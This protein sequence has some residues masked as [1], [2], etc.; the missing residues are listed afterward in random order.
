MGANSPLRLRSLAMIWV[1]LRGVSPSAPLPARKSGIAIGMGWTL[2]W[3]TS[4]L[5]TACARR[6]ARPTTAPAA[7]PVSNR[8]RLVSPLSPS[9]RSSFH[10]L[11]E[12]LN[13][14]GADAAALRN[15]SCGVKSSSTTL[16]HDAYWDAGRKRQGAPLRI[17]RSE[18]SAATRKAGFGLLL[19]TIGSPCSEP[20]R[21]NATRTCTTRSATSS[22]PAGMSQNDSIRARNAPIQLC[23]RNCEFGVGVPSAAVLMLVLVMVCRC[24]SRLSISASLLSIFD[25]SSLGCG[26]FL[27]GAGGFGSGFLASFLSA[28][29]ISSGLSGDLFGSGLAS[30]VLGLASGTGGGAASAEA[31]RISGF[32]STTLPA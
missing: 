13:Y 28:S 14:L 3:V 4:S 25:M 2:P 5:T 30:G 12:V 22:E 18:A 26:G 11:A 7:A 17:A 31:V 16:Q 8:R 23:I 21:L 20:S 32:L 6:G 1:M 10:I 19:S 24:A 15:S 9:E 27:G 29:A